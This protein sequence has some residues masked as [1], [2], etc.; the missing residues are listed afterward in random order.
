MQK[1][2]SNGINWIICCL[3]ALNQI[4]IHQIIFLI[5]VLGLQ[6]RQDP[7]WQK[8]DFSHIR[9]WL[10]IFKKIFRRHSFFLGSV[11]FLTH[12]TFWSKFLLAKCKNFENWKFD[13]TQTCFFGVFLLEMPGMWLQQHKLM[14]KNREGLMMSSMKFSKLAVL[15]W[16]FVISENKV[17]KCNFELHV[18]N[19]VVVKLGF[20][21][22]LNLRTWGTTRI[23]AFRTWWYPI[24]T[25]NSKTFIIIPNS[26]MWKSIFVCEF[27]I[28]NLARY[29]KLFN[30]RKT[31]QQKSK[32]FSKNVFGNDFCFSHS[33]I[34]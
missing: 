28:Y 33:Q 26:V 7:I 3:F 25:K 32:K 24:P 34:G 6:Q 23:L 14:T 4:R 17:E 15:L 11:D 1:L 8:E 10:N 31:S 12:F 5:Q 13:K 18:V 20:R 16:L 30:S 9:H 21:Q 29:S 22:P 19:G 2:K 27:E